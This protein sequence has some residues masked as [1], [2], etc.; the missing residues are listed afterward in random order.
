MAFE[1]HSDWDVYFNQQYENSKNFVLPFIAAHQKLTPESLVLEIGC[2][3]GGV[4]KA[5]TEIGCKVVGVDLSPER[6]KRAE[7]FMKPEMDKGQAK[8][9]AK[10]I[11][12]VDFEKEV[13]RFDAPCQLIEAVDGLRLE[14]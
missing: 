11:Y 5:F 9:I 10:N 8:F 7:Q 13:A 3:E 14:I 1:F 2:A 6:I 12:D 4:L